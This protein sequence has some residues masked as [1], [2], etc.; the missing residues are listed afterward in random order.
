MHCSCILISIAI[1]LRQFAQFVLHEEIV[2]FG[3]LTAQADA[4]AGHELLLCIE[5]GL[6]RSLVA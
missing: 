5:H 1:T 2:C 6:T 4:T 3:L